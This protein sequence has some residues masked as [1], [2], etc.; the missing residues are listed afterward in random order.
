MDS[1]ACSPDE[2]ANDV[3]E[4]PLLVEEMQREGRIENLGAGDARTDGED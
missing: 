3:R 4:I 1:G 2:M